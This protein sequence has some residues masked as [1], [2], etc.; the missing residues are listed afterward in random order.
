M[1]SRGDDLHVRA[2]LIDVREQAVPRRRIQQVTLVDNPLRRALGLT[3]LVLHTAVPAAS[4][5]GVSPVVQVPLLRQADVPAF[6]VRVMG[7]GWAVPEL[8][9]RGPAAARRAVVRRLLLL[10][11]GSIGPGLR[12]GGLSWAAVALA[13]LAVPWGRAAQRRAGHAVAGDRFVALASGVLHHR[14]DLVPLDRVQSARTRSTPFQRRLDLATFRLDVAG[15]TWLGPLTR[16]PGLHD[17]DAA[18]ADHLREA[19]PT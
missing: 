2:G 13:L 16:S 10:L 4:Q 1:T 15:S 12:F 3:S 8:E 7:D 14:I 17:M 5:D 9:R 19:L 18:T 6:L 11:P